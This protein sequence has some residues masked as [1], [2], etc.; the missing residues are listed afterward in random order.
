MAERLK[1]KKLKLELRDS[2]VEFLAQQGYD[3]VAWAL[4]GGSGAAWWHPAAWCM[5]ALDQ[6]LLC[7][8]VAC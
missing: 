4:H 2:G 1:D 7:A 5:V 8:Q 6:S 3:P